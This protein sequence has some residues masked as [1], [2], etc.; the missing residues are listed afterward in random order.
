[1]QISV[2]GVTT[3]IG[4]SNVMLHFHFILPV[5]NNENTNQDKTNS[6]LD[7]LKLANVYFLPLSIVVL[8]LSTPFFVNVTDD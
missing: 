7:V 2:N 1:M 6:A 8:F 5:I 4:T 3:N